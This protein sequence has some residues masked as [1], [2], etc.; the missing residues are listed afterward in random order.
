MKKTSLLI[1]AFIV[2]ALAPKMVSAQW[3]V[4]VDPLLQGGDVHDVVEITCANVTM[5]LAGTSEGVFLDP[6]G[7]TK[8]GRW[9][10]SST[11]LPDAP[12][13]SL[14]VQDSIV[15]AAMYGDGVYTTVI[16]TTNAVA[17]RVEE[18]VPVNT[19]LDNLLVHDL[20]KR[21]SIMYVGT[22]DGIWA[23]KTAMSTTQTFSDILATH[24]WVRVDDTWSQRVFTVERY[25]NLLLGGT[26]LEGA[27]GYNL[28][29]NTS[30]QTCTFYDATPQADFLNTTVY[31]IEPVDFPD[32][33]LEE[34]TEDIPCQ[35]V[36][37]A[38]GYGD[39]L[40]LAPVLT[41]STQP[42][43]LDWWQD[44]SLTKTNPNWTYK[45]N[46]ILAGHFPGAPNS[47]F[48]GTEYGGV[49]YSFDCGQTWQE[50]N[51]GTNNVGLEGADVRSLSVIRDT[52]LIAGAVGGT[53]FQGTAFGALSIPQLVHVTSVES[54][55]SD[56]TDVQPELIVGTDVGSERGLVRLTLPEEQ[57]ENVR[58]S[59]Y[60]LLGKQI[61]V[62][63]DGDLSDETLQ[64]EFDV[65]R[66]HTGVYIC[67]A[68]GPDFKL[69][70]KFVISR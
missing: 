68:E 54:I 10:V 38:A 21:D 63:Y 65:S 39:N 52:V 28:R 13:H 25:R 59:T 14:L 17:C 3:Q 12:V 40:Y 58:I 62:L 16:S 36:V 8:P 11:G 43:T 5:V 50:Y 45:V 22:E 23:F 20:V 37:I 33:L 1:L 30:T 49:F 61:G 42:A 64:I 70:R 24:S 29:C 67:I 41:D 47:L 19:G 53:Y 32:V 26:F 56:T 7:S 15:F 51:T 18:W 69:A 55:D 2:T 6:I 4:N 35:G 31:D 48:V 60:N 57:W 34:G 9:R 27:W 44:I 46:T 66:L